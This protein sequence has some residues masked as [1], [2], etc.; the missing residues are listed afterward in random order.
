MTT[1]LHEESAR[2]GGRLTE[3]RR[4]ESGPGVLRLEC[5]VLRPDGTEYDDRWWPVSDAQLVNLQ[6]AGTNIIDL[7]K[8]EAEGAL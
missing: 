7:L 2:E 1:Y 4:G 3:Y 8:L 6:L 5:R